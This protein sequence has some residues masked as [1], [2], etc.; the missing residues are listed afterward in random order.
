LT[1]REAV[2][3]DGISPLEAEMFCEMKIADLPRA[4]TQP[5]L[6]V[7]TPRSAST[8]RRSRQLALKF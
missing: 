2:V 6:D 5:V 7:E 4:A 1:N 3:A 8:R